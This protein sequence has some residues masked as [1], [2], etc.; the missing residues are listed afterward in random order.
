[1]GEILVRKF[2][3]F[4]TDLFILIFF[5]SSRTR[6]LSACFTTECGNPGILK[7]MS[8]SFNIE[9]SWF[10]SRQ[11]TGFTVLSCFVSSFTLKFVLSWEK[12]V[13]DAPCSWHM[14]RQ[15]TGFSVLSWSGLG[16][17][18]L[19]WNFWIVEQLLPLVVEQFLNPILSS[20]HVSR[21][22]LEEDEVT[23]IPTRFWLLQFPS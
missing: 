8:T 12:R 17:G 21:K 16:F 7:S 9:R 11:T 4:D 20:S 10:A 23:H 6:Q 5:T 19:D 3:D 22:S 2:I 15:T 1:M 13:W 14:S 18:C